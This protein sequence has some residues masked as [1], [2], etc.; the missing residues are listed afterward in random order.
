MIKKRALSEARSLAGGVSEEV[1]APPRPTAGRALFRDFRDQRQLGDHSPELRHS[2]H[3]VLAG[4]AEAREEVYMAS[5]PYT[6]SL[7]VLRV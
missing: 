2:A 7:T 4:C 1:I 3:L 5:G 6:R